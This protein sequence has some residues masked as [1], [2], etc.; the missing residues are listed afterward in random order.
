MATKKTTKPK[1]SN[2]T[3]QVATRMD[4]A[5][6]ARL[7]AQTLGNDRWFTDEVIE[8]GTARDNNSR[9]LPRPPAFETA[10]LP[11]ATAASK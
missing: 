6:F 4:V 11:I 9:R 1:A 2:L 10:G 5:S 8:N 3:Q 7:L